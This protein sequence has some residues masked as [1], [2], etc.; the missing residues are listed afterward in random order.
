MNARWKVKYERGW[1][2][3]NHR[4]EEVELAYMTLYPTRYH[5][6]LHQHC[7]GLNTPYPVECGNL[8]KLCRTP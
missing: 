4:R 8:G 6:H 3:V 5:R 1:C 7:H 2:P